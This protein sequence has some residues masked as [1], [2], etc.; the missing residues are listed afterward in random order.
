MK[1]YNFKDIQTG[2]IKTKKYKT[3]ND[4][5]GDLYLAQQVEIETTKLI[6]NS[7]VAGWEQAPNKKC[8]WDVKLHK[9]D[10]SVDILEYKWDCRAAETSNICIP[11]KNANGEWE[12]F[13]PNVTY[14]VFV[15]VDPKLVNSVKKIIVIDA[16]KLREHIL[17]NIDIEKEEIKDRKHF[18]IGKGDYPKKRFLLLMNVFNKNTGEITDTYKDIVKGYR[19]YKEEKLLKIVV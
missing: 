7:N 19:Q 6:A 11:F 2:K 1:I 3:E 5:A 9:I 13:F 10:G 4:F 15:I 16:A 14:I 17:K 18:Y 12:D 8:S